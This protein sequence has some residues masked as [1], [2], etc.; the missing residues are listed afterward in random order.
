[1][2]LAERRAI[3]S[4]AD[5]QW[6]ALQTAIHAA[7]GSAIP[8]EVHWDSLATA[9]YAHLYEESLP[10]L[11]F[12]PLIDALK[13]IAI[14]DMG[15]EALATSV[16]KIVI[17]NKKP[18]YSSYWAEFKDGVLTLDHQFTN[19]DYHKERE[20]LVVQVLEKAL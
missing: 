2:G 9:D 13:R 8:V 16:K 7:A 5:N 19:V 15:R 1:M 17:Q 6:P 4:F 18:D 3:K 20:D 12:I 14:D 10:K 11:Y